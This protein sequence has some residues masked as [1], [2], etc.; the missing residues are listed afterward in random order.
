[1]NMCKRFFFSQENV[2]KGYNQGYSNIILE[3][4]LKKNPFKNYT[5]YI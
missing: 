3:K 4:K 5:M 2:I 1:M